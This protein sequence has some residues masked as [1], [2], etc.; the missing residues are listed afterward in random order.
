[1]GECI[2]TQNEGLGVFFGKLSE[3]DAQSNQKQHPKHPKNSTQTRSGDI[4]RVVKTP[5]IQ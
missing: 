4:L 2:T 3:S 1:M 5:Q